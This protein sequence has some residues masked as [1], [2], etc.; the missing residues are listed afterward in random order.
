M[1]KFKVFVR[2]ENTVTM[3]VK[4]DWISEQPYSKKLNKLR[5]FRDNFL[6]CIRTRLFAHSFNIFLDIFLNSPWFVPRLFSLFFYFLPDGFTF[7]LNHFLDVDPTFLLQLFLANFPNLFFYFFPSFFR[8]LV[9]CLFLQ[10][11]PDIFI[12]KVFFIWVSYE[13]IYLNLRITNHRITRYPI[14]SLPRSKLKTNANHTDST[15]SPLSRTCY[16]EWVLFGSPLFISLIYNP[17]WG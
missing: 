12:N 3:T 15:I 6:Q 5:L 8:D 1:K 17:I 4:I 2:S 10:Y 7:F 13:I 11:S 14:V 16:S 9:F